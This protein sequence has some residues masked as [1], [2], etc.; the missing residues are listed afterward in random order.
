MLPVFVEQ[1]MILHRVAQQ[2]LGHGIAPGSDVAAL[3][4][5]LRRLVDDR[6]CRLRAVNFARTYEGYQPG[7][8]IDAVADEIHELLTQRPG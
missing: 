1:M 5:A 2:G 7:V 4:A 6:A 3:D 8:T